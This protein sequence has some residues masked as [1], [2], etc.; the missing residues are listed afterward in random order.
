MRIVDYASNVDGHTIP[1]DIKAR[2]FDI[3]FALSLEW[4][5]A[6]IKTIQ[7]AARSGAPF[8]KPTW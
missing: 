1:G 8:V 4:A 7:G 6:E 5:V 3:D 2:K